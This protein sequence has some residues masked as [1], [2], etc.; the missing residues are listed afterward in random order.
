MLCPLTKARRVNCP[1]PVG[2]RWA[3]IQILILVPGPRP[4]SPRIV[5]QILSGAEKRFFCS[6]NIKVI[7]WK[8]SYWAIFSLPMFV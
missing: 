4:T 8:K 6:A 2:E 7:L 3:G 1:F 5:S